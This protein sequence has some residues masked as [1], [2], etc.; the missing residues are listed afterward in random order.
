MASLRKFP[1]SPFWFACYTDG[2]GKRRQVS[3]KQTDR[4]GALRIALEHERAAKLARAG[5]ATAAQFRKILSETLEAVTGGEETLRSVAT[6]EYLNAWLDSKEAD[7]SLS[8][9]T[10]ARYSTTISQFLESLNARAEKPLTALRPADF[11]RFYD[12]RA[13]AGLAAGTLDVDM[14]TLRAAIER[15]RRHG[16]IPTN[17][18]EAI[19]L[20]GRVTQQDRELFTKAEIEMLLAQ[21]RG[22]EWETAILVGAYTAQRLGDCV[23]LRWSKIDLTNGIVEVRQ[24]KT[25]KTLKLPIHQRLLAH[26][27]SKAGIDSAQDFVTPGLAKGRV[28]GCTGLSKQFAEIMR[29]AGVDQRKTESASGRTFSTRSFHSLRHTVNSMLADAGVPQE[30]RMRITGHSSTKVNDG[31]TKLEVE[32]LRRDVNGNL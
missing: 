18:V 2:V 10:L 4:S 31:Y 14:K 9:S 29:K 13:K 30:R 22:T 16:L 26:L 20:P 1:E 23:S 32:K 24:A 21:A 7:P 25:G 19:D 5:N 6:R 3:T 17:P 28:S 15:A 11:Q 27:E 8:R 12:L